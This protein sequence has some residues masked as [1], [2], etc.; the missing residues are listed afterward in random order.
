VNTLRWILVPVSA[1]VAF[2]AP[3]VVA[4]AGFSLINRLCPPE[5]MV[6]G[7]C[8]ASWSGLA[9]EALVILC[10][11]LSAIGVVLVPAL[12][13]P[14]RKLKVATLAFTGGA[15]LAIYIALHGSL[16]ELLTAALVGGG[17]ALWFA[18]VTWRDK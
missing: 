5:L 2:Y 18:S 14:E 16:W 10:A 12:V 8:T 9:T 6:S 11:A 3:T 17:L 1:I 15:L 7:S 4:I 13:A